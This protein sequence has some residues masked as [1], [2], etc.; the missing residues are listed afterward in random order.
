MKQFVLLVCF[1]MAIFLSLNATSR[2]DDDLRDTP[3]FSAMPNYYVGDAADK[4]FDTY[5]FPDGKK[6]IAVEGKLWKKQYWLRENARQASELQIMKN[7]SN[8]VKSMGG[9]V[10]LEGQCSDCDAGGCSGNTMTGTVSKGGREIWIAA[11][12]CNDGAD[13]TLVVVEKEAMKQDV[14]ANEMLEALNQQGFVALHINF[15]TGKAAIKPESQ[16]L[17]DQVAKLLKNNPSLTVS[18]EGHTDNVGNSAK[19]KELS[20]Q[21]AESVVN[22]LTKQGIAAKRLSAAGWGQEKPVADNKTEEG[23]A[24]NRRVEIVKK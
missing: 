14:T 6:N 3:Y 5:S 17:V 22:A 21:R 1:S 10:L 16:P 19:N 23:K 8:A 11:I 12:P 18:I 9:K 7:Y 15:D 4:E 24:K 2:G 20:K 13:Y